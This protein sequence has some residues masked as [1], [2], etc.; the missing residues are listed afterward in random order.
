MTGF[1]K[2]LFGG[3]EKKR[4]EGL[5][6]EILQ[7]V[8][9]KSQIEISYDLKIEDR[10]NGTEGKLLTIEMF[11]ADEELVT[12]REGQLLDAF[13]L[14]F[15]RVLQHNFPDQRIDVQ[16]D[17]NGYREEMNKTLFQLADKL[18]RVAIDK[19]RSVYLRALPP[20]DRKVIHQY[21]ADDERIKSRSV[22]DGLYKK[23]K[24]YPAK[25]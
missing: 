25:N 5:I 9:D 6:N 17:C 22:G 16:F 15:K 7:G 24:I 3:K 12:E 11:G 2:R 14:Y 10:S 19:K 20:K 21:L 8:I 1:L 23:I 4:E 18:K 13:Q